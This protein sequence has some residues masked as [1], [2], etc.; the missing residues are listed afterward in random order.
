MSGKN[1]GQRINVEFCV[2]FVKSAR[3][4]LA[5]ITVVY[6]EYA[7]AKSSVFERHWW[8]EKGRENVQD[9]PRSGQPKT[10]RTDE[11][12]DRVPTLVRSDGRLDVRVIQ[13]ELNVNKET[14]WHIVEEDLRT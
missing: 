8:F 13:E 10:Q 9:E 4:I 3:E 12:M 14:V 7:L 2:K 11:N 5:Q 6:G 1:L